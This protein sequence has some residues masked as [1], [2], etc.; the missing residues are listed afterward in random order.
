MPARGSPNWTV[1]TAPVGTSDNRAASTAFVRSKIKTA[2]TYYVRTDGSDA[3]NGFSDTAAGAFLTLQKAADT[4]SGSIDFNNQTVTIQVRAGTYAG[5]AISPWVGAGILL[6]DGDLVTASNVLINSA[7]SSGGAAISIT[8]GALGTLGLQGF[9][10]AGSG[11]FGINVASPANIVMTNWEWGAI[12][13]G[14]PH[15][16]ATCGGA[17]IS[18]AA[19]YAISGGA[20]QHL[21]ASNGGKIS[22]SGA[23]VA[24]LT[25]TPA[26]SLAFAQADHG[27]NIITSSLFSFSG[28]A[29]GPRYNAILN[30][31][32]DTGGG[33]P[34]FFPGNAP[35]T[36]TS[37][38][39]YT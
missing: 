4:V 10:I 9:K 25:G 24:T 30:G 35:G 1:P 28:A 20:S 33:G 29:T 2:L 8:K 39:Q 21:I 26:F 11:F 3:N 31:I 38:G 18:L 37:G 32:I 13:G 7:A 23:I 5:V 16:A 15:I 6:I 17:N 19:S 12:A 36:F 22:T 34:T 14:L 27:G